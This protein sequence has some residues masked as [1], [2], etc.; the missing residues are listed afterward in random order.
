MHVSHGLSTSAVVMTGTSRLAK[1]GV[2]RHDV[3]GLLADSEKSTLA[4]AEAKAS[5]LA[6]RASGKVSLP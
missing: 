3:L 2:T 4:A 1:K 6:A 5:L